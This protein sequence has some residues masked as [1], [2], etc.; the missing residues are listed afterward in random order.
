M[1]IIRATV[2]N[3][4]ELVILFDHY[5]Q[6]YAQK[7][8]LPHARQFLKERMENQESVLFVAQAN[9][10]LLGF[11][12]LYPSFT[13]VGMARA[14]LLN[15]LFVAEE[16]RGK[17]VATALIQK[18][19]SFSKESGRKKIFLAT[20]YDNLQAQQLYEKIGFQKDPFF[21]YEYLVGG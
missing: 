2:E 8:D 14:W 18:V 13:S 20:A 3:L 5:R 7:S 11:T 16:S 10:E 1:Q 21:N 17:G 15:D 12:Q 19:I 9:D 6:F 4:D